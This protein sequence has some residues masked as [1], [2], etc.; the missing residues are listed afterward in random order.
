MEPLESVLEI[1]FFD[2]FKISCTT[3]GVF[4]I[5][6]SISYVHVHLRICSL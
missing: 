1:F 4:F 2:L 5:P 6:G 3:K